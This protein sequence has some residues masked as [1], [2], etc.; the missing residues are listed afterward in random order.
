MSDRHTQV[1]RRSYL[2]LTAATIA[3]ATAPVSAQDGKADIREP[4]I[5]D[6]M[7]TTTDNVELAT[8]VYLPSDSGRFP[9]VVNRTPYDKGDGLRDP[10]MVALLEAGYA[11]V[12]QDCRGR[13]KSEGMWEPVF[14]EQED[15]YDTVEWAADQEWSTGKVGMVGHSYTAQ[16]AW[17]AAVADPPSLEAIAA[18]QG[19]INTYRDVWFSGGAFELGLAI[20]WA[21]GRSMDTIG[22]L[23]VSAEEKAALRAELTNPA[24]L[25]D[26][27]PVNENPGFD[28]FV[29]PY[30]F[31][32]LLHDT[33]EEY[34]ERIDVLQYIDEVSAK[35]LTVG[36]FYDIFLEGQPDVWTAIE[37]RGKESVRESQHMILGPWDHR[38][39]SSEPVGE[40]K[41]SKSAGQVGSPDDVVKWF[42]KWLKDDADTDQGFPSVQYYQTGATPNTDQWRSAETWPPEATTTQE[43]YLNSNG[44]ANSSNGDGTLSSDQPVYGADTD[45]YEYDPLDPVPTAGGPLLQIG[46]MAGVVDQRTVEAR[47]DVLVFTSERLAE[48]LEVVGNP[49]VTLHVEST[50]PDTDFSV[51]LVDVHPDGYAAN[52]TEKHLRARY[53]ETSTGESYREGTFMEPG[54]VYELS[55]DLRPVAHTFEKGHRL[56]LVVTSSNFPRLDRNP[57]RAMDVASATEE[58]M[59]SATNTVY[60]SP[61]HRSGISL[62]IREESPAKPHKNPNTDKDCD[63]D[64]DTEMRNDGTPQTE[65]GENTQR[66][67]SDN[68][69]SGLGVSAAM[70]GIGGAATWMK[71]RRSED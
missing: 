33:Y 44:D 64:S 48:P 5:R 39:P 16:T 26:T 53:R 9:T 12:R 31:E 3:A 57:N 14:Y 21:A 7:M 2:A 45:D 19:P 17:H 27:L 20:S 63:A 70:A 10:N 1:R 15:G 69:K 34:W 22:R 6:K 46:E 41:L 58:E 52:I 23:P 29:A 56:R 49:D 62:P 43:L 4:D 54:T 24:D 68:I 25:Y 37:N 30:Y 59:Q 51:K 61:A 32:W 35:V 40:R 71:E 42:D 38:L 65:S 55:I 11:V 50:A 60:H 66:A 13:Y 28:E 18:F 67:E 8:D 47:D 36:G